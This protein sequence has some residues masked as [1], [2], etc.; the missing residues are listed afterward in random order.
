MP[1]KLARRM[2]FEKYE[3]YRMLEPLQRMSAS[4]TKS[5]RKLSPSRR[6]FS[7]PIRPLIIPLSRLL[8]RNL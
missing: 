1:R 5:I 4:S 7:G 6:A 3:R 2:K 8:Q